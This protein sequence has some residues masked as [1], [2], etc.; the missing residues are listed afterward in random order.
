MVQRHLG[1][2]KGRYY[3]FT[4][5]QH[6][7]TVCRGLIETVFNDQ[8]Q[9]CFSVMLPGGF[10]FRAYKSWILLILDC[11]KLKCS[12]VFK[13]GSRDPWRQESLRGESVRGPNDRP[14][15]FESLYTLMFFC[16]AA[17][18]SRP[19]FGVK[20]SGIAGSVW[21]LSWCTA[22]FFGVLGWNSAN[23]SLLSDVQ[24]AQALLASSWHIESTIF[25]QGGGTKSSIHAFAIT[26]YP[27]V[28]VA[29]GGGGIWRREGHSPDEPPVYHEDGIKREIS[30]HA[31]G[32][33]RVFGPWEEARSFP[34]PLENMHR[35]ASSD[36]NLQP[37]C[38]EV[39]VPLRRFAAPETKSTR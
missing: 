23:P 14:A 38:C 35:K 30:I 9:R 16:R 17:F 28:R 21:S 37:S 34:Y 25:Y 6:E 1:V 24:K 11:V 15:A 36:S 32:E 3:C 19:D 22:G 2:I 33:F 20:P 27:A 8:R 18:A 12:D 26:A 29:G 4:V 5:P 39:T 7:V 10:T 13:M 31:Y